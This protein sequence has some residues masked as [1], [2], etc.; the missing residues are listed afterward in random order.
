[1]FN[2][3][4]GVRPLSSTPFLP[5]PSLSS[6]HLLG[7]AQAYQAIGNLE[8]AQKWYVEAVEK[9]KIEYERNPTDLA[10]QAFDT[11]R[12]KYH[13][14]LQELPLSEYQEQSAVAPFDGQSS[15]SPSQNPLPPCTG[16]NASLSVSNA[17]QSEQ[18]DH[19]FE[20]ALSTFERLDVLNKVSLF[21]VY[22]HDNPACGQAKASIAKYLIKKLSEIRVNLYSD[23]TPMGQPATS[24]EESGSVQQLEDILTSQFCLL[25]TQLIEGVAP[26]GKV[27]VC[28]SEVLG[29]YLKWPD[30]KKFYQALREA[31]FKDQETYRIDSAQANASAIREVVRQ[32]SQEPE[33]KAGFHHVL[34]EIAF[35]Q[36]REERLKDRHGIISVPL[37]PQSHV[38]C[39]AHFIAETAVRIGDIPRFEAQAQAGREVY[40]NQSL[41]L[42]LFKL[43][44]RLLGESSETKLFLNK[45]WEGYDDLI[46]RLKNKPSTLAWSEFVK[47]LD[48]IFDDI[49]MKQL[50]EQAQHLSQMRMQHKE[51][52]QKLLPPTFSSVDLRE[53]LYQYYK[54]S[55]LSIQ[56]VSGQTMLL[57]DCYINLAIVES[58]AYREKDQEELKRQ[59]TT[60]ERLPSAERLKTTNFNKLIPLE[61]LFEK[62]K[63][64]DGSENIP[65][66]ILIQ[67]R[68]GIGKTTLCKKIVHEYYHN[69][70][71]RDRFDNILWIPLRQLKTA[72]SHYLEDLLCH[73]YFSHYGKAKA[74]ALGKAFLDYQDK[75]LFILDGLDEVTE[76][77]SENHHLNH[78]FK[79][80][81]NQPHVLI[82]SRPAGVNASQCN[83]LDLELETI[84]FSSE[85]VR[86]YIQKF[87]PESNQ[88]AIQRF[89]DHTPL[90]QGL[91]NIPIQLDVLCYSWENL[92]QNQTVTMTSLYEAM[93]NK[94]WLKDSKRLKKRNSEEELTEFKLG[95]RMAPEIHYLS[96]LAFKGLETGKIE[97]SWNDLSECEKEL[98]AAGGIEIDAY[99]LKKTS[100]LHTINAEEPD[101]KKRYYHFLHLTFQEFFAAKFLV[102][103]LQAYTN[104]ERFSAYVDGV[105]KSLGFMPKHN[106]VEAFIATH[107]YNPRYEIIWWM[108]AGLL[109]GAALERFFTLFEQSP[110]D[111]IGGRHQQ[112][113]IGCLSETRNQLNP[114]TVDGL[115]KELTQWVNFEMKRGDESSGLGRQQ[116]F[117]ERLLLKWLDQSD[118]LKIPIILT[119]GRRLTLSKA[120]MQVL[121]GTSQNENEEVR[122]AAIHAL[123]CQST[124]PKAA[125]QVLIDAFQDQSEYIKVVAIRALGGQSMLTEAAEEALVCA[126][127]HRNSLI[128]HEAINAL[129]KQKTLSEAAERALI[130]ALRHRDRFRRSEWFLRSEAAHTLEKQE[131]LSEAAEQV[132]ISA[133]QHED[134]WVSFDAA[135]TLAKQ[136]TLSEAAVQAFIGALQYGSAIVRLPV[137]SALEKQKTLSETAMQALAGALQH[138][139]GG[140]RSRAASVLKKQETLSKVA[141]QA[142]VG[143]LKD[144]AKDV[145]SA[146]VYALEKQETLSEA[147]V[148]ALISALKDQDMIVRL[149]AA[150]AL[151]KQE[152]L[153][154]AAVQALISSLESQVEAAEYAEA[155]L[156]KKQKTLSE[157]AIQALIGIL[158][159]GDMAVRYAVADVLGTHVDL[160]YPI[161]PNLSSSQIEVLYT[162]FLFNYSC[163]HIAALYV[164]DHQLHF[165]T[166]RGLGRVEVEKPGKIIQ[167]FEAVQIKGGIKSMRKE[168]LLLKEA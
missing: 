2:F 45:F 84:G 48:G 106:E 66:R 94:L 58:R 6:Q 46:S 114:K 139:N 110:R 54:R 51:I 76:I 124:L 67:G 150:R 145:R 72:S 17:V 104:V 21:L 115:E 1:M 31:Y 133:L 14:F 41:H 57:D 164:Q 32:F 95:K 47:L 165:Y 71:W 73:H 156:L 107:K 127:Q 87:A 166:E 105:Q 61:Q 100:I 30:Y 26:V 141:V 152:T 69:G 34:T 91:V 92:P 19:L 37:T 53:A 5:H 74:Q 42:V 59:A 147:A 55:N 88:A 167:A 149:T 43:I 128:V 27:V 113:L 52:I 11:V 109:K 162:K 13:V 16:G 93:V 9:A 136:E 122:L 126:L 33:Y 158:Q 81:L 75:T 134:R 63:L 129:E 123:G 160:I 132:L 82:T 38:S 143:V 65:K 130:D 4:A 70:L 157:A 3:I 29:N 101:E 50:R 111:L 118:D 80:L 131:T 22:A 146:A 77:F 103:H 137:S 168:A 117:P 112:V 7:Q 68:A 86:T 159:S 64:R 153:S 135:S 28:C 39:L 35:L 44:E 10:K 151:E 89:I 148:Q 15:I 120:A 99:T 24:S 12:D 155:S 102:K 96:Y 23:Q 25:P 140:I 8:E 60:F 40:P 97:F 125:V 142:L 36:I 154:E 121:I 108:L 18:V 138:E 161:L 144:Q 116:A 85:N 62:Q 119:L 49:W 98:D 79:H 163:E 56:R 20:K 78:F 83:E 90:I